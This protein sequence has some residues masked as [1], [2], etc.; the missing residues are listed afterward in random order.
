MAV[1]GGCDEGGG[2][3]GSSAN[4]AKTGDAKPGDTKAAD[5]KSA[6]A[7]VTLKYADVEAAYEKEIN[8]LAK[9]KDPMDKKIEAFVAKIGKPEKEDGDKKIWHAVDGSKCMKITIESSG[10][11]T[12]ETVDNAECGL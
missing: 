5:T 2:G 10:V 1:L 11:K 7:A 12:D 9:M 3:A 6:K 8:D 4:D